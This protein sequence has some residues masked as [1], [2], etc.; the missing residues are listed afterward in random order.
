VTAA[1]LYFEDDA[2]DRQAYSRRLTG[3]DTIVTGH[4]PP[5]DL[6]LEILRDAWDLFLVDYE[7]MGGAAGE[8]ANYK[9][10]T[11]G[12]NLRERVPE[13]PVVLFT[14]RNLLPQTD[15]H[16]LNALQVF[17][18]VV[19][20]GDVDRDPGE[21][22]G[23]LKRLAEGFGLMRGSDRTWATGIRLLGAHESEVA[24]L[25]E[26]APPLIGGIWAP[27][28]FARW[29]VRTLFAYPGP[30][31]D[32]LHAAALLGVAT[33]SFRSGPVQELLSDTR[34][35]GVLD[36]PEGRWWRDRVL[37]VG[38]DLVDQMERKGPLFESFAPAVF[39]RSGQALLAAKC[40]HCGETP[41][42][43]VCYILRAPVKTEHSLQYY[44]D[45]R[46]SVMEPA[47]VSF[48]AIRESNDV[49]EDLIDP[50]ARSLVERLHEDETL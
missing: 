20:K 32:E 27:S 42:D 11:L 19:F 14:R 7:L 6:S 2:G 18:D 31:K 15:E 1:V 29:I 47:R 48:K 46:P 5:P 25:Q 17:D 37:R 8:R 23:R 4:P 43:S 9:G 12:M 36:P 3:D 38:R 41:A 35:R 50:N 28:E 30:L 24:Q 22:S 10:G 39:A 21:I 49:D 45:P 44:P 33:E 26:A 13:Y 16:V 40:V 34:Y